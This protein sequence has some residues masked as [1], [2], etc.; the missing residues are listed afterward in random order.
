MVQS[1]CTWC[2]QILKSKSKE[3]LKVLCWSGIGGTKFT[4]VYNFP[5]QLSVVLH[6]E[7]RAFGGT[8]QKAEIAFVEKYTLVIFSHFRSLR[9]RKIS[10]LDSQSKFQMFTQFLPAAILED[11]GGPPTMRPHTKLYNFKRNISKNISTL[12]QRTHLKLGELSSLFIV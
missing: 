11:Q 10:P 7:T 5:A 3:P 6:L 2:H 4:S 12:G 1:M 9:I 8:W